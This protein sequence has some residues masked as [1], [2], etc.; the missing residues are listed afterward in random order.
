MIFS[1]DFSI[2]AKA[3]EREHLLVSIDSVFIESVN[4]H[5]LPDPPAT[6][7]TFL[8][9]DTVTATV[10]VDMYKTFIHGEMYI[11]TQELVCLIDSIVNNIKVFTDY[12]T[13]QYPNHTIVSGEEEIWNCLATYKKTL[14]D[15]PRKMRINI[16]CICKV[17]NKGNIHWV[18]LIPNKGNELTL[19]DELAN[20]LKQ[21]ITKHIKWNEI[22]E[23]MLSDFIMFS[24]VD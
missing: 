9:Q 18:T 20:K 15:Q 10:C 22:K 21:I 12:P 3:D 24:I 19:S 6:C 1:I 16:R 23:R 4:W 5:I 2:S 11:T 7:M 14:G 13:P 8:S 17:D